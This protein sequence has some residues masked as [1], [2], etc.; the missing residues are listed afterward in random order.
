MSS[1]TTLDRRDFLSW[2]G[3]GMCTLAARPVL[4]LDGQTIEGSTKTAAGLDLQLTASPA[5]SQLLP[6]R[7]TNTWAYT[8]RVLVG[9]ASAATPIA[10][11]YL[12]PIIRARRGQ[13]MRV[14]FINGLREP[15]I[16]HWHGMHVRPEMDGHPRDAVAPGAEYAYEFPITDRAGT[17]WFHPHPHGRTGVQVYN[18]LAGLLLVSDEEE[19]AA[20]L[21]SGDYDI[22]LVI[23]DRSFDSAN[24]F[25]YTSMGHGGH[26]GGA[27]GDTILVN[28]RAGFT[29][30]VQRS[31]YRLR[32]VNASNSRIYK[33]GW[34]D[35]SPLTVISTD[36]GLLE[37][38]LARPYVTLAPGERVDVI[39]DFRRYRKGTSL[40]ML[41]RA[42]SG[43]DMGGMMGNTRIP[44]G[45][46]FSVFTVRMR[47]RGPQG[48]EMP[49]RLSTISRYRLE[50]AT[51]AVSPRRLALTMDPPFG[52]SIN[53]R[54]FEMDE[55]LPDE[56]V[57]L[58]ALEA[59]DIENTS[60]GMH[61]AG[62][63]HPIHLHG[64]QFQV[65]ERQID[66]RFEA[67]WRSVS[68]GFVDE[69]WK[70]TVLVMPGER[71]R[72]LVRFDDF[73][74]VYLVHCHN[75][76][77]SDAGMARNFEIAV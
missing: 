43:A 25:T 2:V 34:S 5:T 18:G 49:S 65:F 72:V 51:N 61:G 60:A 52:W 22:P 30:D 66:P 1:R 53:G 45:A 76:E 33:L 29:L 73:A 54:T 50:D 75:L 10:D 35:E 36:G 31:V 20:R 40:R 14:R 28:G 57:R 59:W 58:G 68:A 9:D 41:S 64:F 38:P 63:A 12:G 19:D 39:A 3:L 13:S 15:S 37:A 70:D 44:N 77:H 24:Q 47:R 4:A 21:P 16:V 23:Q 17:Y 26:F 11:G 6:G 42:F 69:G 48:F 56:V 74:G 71:V 62:M 67:G 27:L 8:A 32:L 46:E 55:V 7:T